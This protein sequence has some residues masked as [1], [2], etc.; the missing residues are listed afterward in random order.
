MVGGST[1]T[2][3]WRSVVL[4]SG[5]ISASGQGRQAGA[6][7]AP[8]LP[9]HACAA[10][11]VCDAGGAGFPEL[12]ARQS[13]QLGG[14]TFRCLGR[15]RHGRGMVAGSQ[16]IA[17]ALRRNGP[18]TWRNSGLARAKGLARL[19]R[20]KGDSRGVTFG[21]HWHKAHTG[22]AS[23]KY[24]SRGTKQTTVR[25]GRQFPKRK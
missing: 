17:T 2:L 25:F 9:L 10:H 12:T 18:P 7:T 5:M 21:A 19:I 24:F 22:P 20:D 16:R 13:P 1:V 11:A 14:P 8:S 3:G 15:R 4:S 6:A 23:C